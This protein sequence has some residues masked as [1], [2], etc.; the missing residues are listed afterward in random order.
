MGITMEDVRALQFS[1]ED[2]E[3]EKKKEVANIDFKMIGF[4]LAGKDY[5][6]DIMKVKEIAKAG[7]FTFVPNTESFVLGVYN[8]RG[9]IIPI[10][11]LRVF[12]NIDVP[13]RTSNDVENLII[14]SIEDRVFGVVVDEIDKVVGIQKKNIQPPHPLFGDIN[15]KYIYGVIESNNRLYILLDI[16]RVFG[17]HNSSETE[18]LSVKIEEQE[19]LSITTESDK[20]KQEHFADPKSLSSLNVE[21]LETESQ[22]QSA[23]KD[24]INTDNSKI[25]VE[26]ATQNISE[27]VIPEDSVEQSSSEDIDTNEDINC[28]FVSDALVSFANF[29]VSSINENWF[30]RRYKEWTAAKDNP[31]ITSK[32]Q[33][34]E[35]LAPFYSRY[36]GELWQEDYCKEVM[37]L[38]PDNNAKQINVWNPGCGKGFET[39]SLACVFQERY[40]NS[41]I[42]IYAQDFD[43]LNISNAPLLT[44]TEGKI[45][46]FFKPYV[47]KTVKNTFSFS[48]KIKDCIQFE[49]HDCTHNNTNP[50]VDH[51]FVR[52]LLSFISPDDLNNLF[53]DIEDNLKG[54]GT[55]IVGDN[56]VLADHSKWL[57]KS[58]D[59]LTIYSKT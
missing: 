53:V 59:S 43:L 55:I 38:L 37:D 49:Y 50:S 34:D 31:Q 26:Q 46:D 54:N 9:E 51:I 52:D 56:E 36:S 17:L 2:I 44:V 48:Q 7:K 21:T 18:D 11:D 20:G 6:I 25:E 13:E 10:I 28:K 35:F 14:V 24:G 45:P 47:V 23:S 57:E 22:S 3:D 41:K 5:A 12:F 58:K 42:K 32:D 16:E 40:P 30:K 27:E 29:Y 4:S 15:I 1:E 19:T 33:A 8:L 39:F